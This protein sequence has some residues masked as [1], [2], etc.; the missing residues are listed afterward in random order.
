MRDYNSWL[1]LHTDGSGSSGMTHSVSCTLSVVNGLTVA[2]C[3]SPV[4][5]EMGR[6]PRLITIAAIR[7]VVCMLRIGPSLSRLSSFIVTIQ[8]LLGLH[9]VSVSHSVE[10]VWN[11]SAPTGHFSGPNV[12]R[13]IQLS[14]E[15]SLVSVA[16][17][18]WRKLHVFCTKVTIKSWSHFSFRSR[19]KGKELQLTFLTRKCCQFSC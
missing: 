13:L 5:I 8:G 9:G 14:D 2:S 16:L 12:V 15:C 18:T 1:R 17:K 3:M 10:R 11:V 4:Y 6:D 19:R 7:S